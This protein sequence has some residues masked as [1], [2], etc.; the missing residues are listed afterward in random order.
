MTSDG[1]WSNKLRKISELERP[2]HV[3][4]TED[5]ECYFF[6][7]YTPRAGFKHS[8]TNQIIA[9]LKKPPSFRGQ[10]A[11]KYKGQAIRICASVLAASLNKNA[12]NGLRIV[13]IPPSKSPDDGDYDDRILQVALRATPFRTVELLTTRVTRDAAHC[14][15]GGRS[16]DNVYNSLNVYP[17]RYDGGNICVLIDDVLTTGASFKAC[18][19]KV[20]EN[21]QFDKVIGIFAARCVWPKMQWPADFAIEL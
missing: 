15:N 21:G 17:E 8:D 4:L 14:L 2:D 18:K 5:D 10:Y 20:L 9:N 16:I 11:W 1:S 7:D 12:V 13:P 3:F 6:G 19:R